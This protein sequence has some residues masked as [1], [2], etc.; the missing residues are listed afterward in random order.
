MHPPSD[1]MGLWVSVPAWINQ[2]T[3]LA[4]ACGLR[5]YYSSSAAAVSVR[6][7]GVEQ[8]YSSRASRCEMRENDRRPLGSESEQMIEGVDKARREG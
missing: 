5:Q 2:R 8:L 6:R 7:C 4:G 3:A 1:I